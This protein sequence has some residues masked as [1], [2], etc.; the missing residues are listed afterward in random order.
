MDAAVQELLDRTRVIERVTEFFVATDARDWERL[1]RLMTDPVVLDMTSLAGGNPATVTPAQVGAG[2]RD[3]LAA[4]DHVHHQVGNFLVKVTGDEATLRC[5]GL[6]F[7]HRAISSPDNLRTFVGSYDV[8][9]RRMAD[10]WKI[11][12]FRFKVSFVT[13]NLKLETAE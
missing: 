9:L 5:Y 6:A 3:G 2:W 12:L 13:G 1:E 7:H 8:E 10:E 4:I 11:S